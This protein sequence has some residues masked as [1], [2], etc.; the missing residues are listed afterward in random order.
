MCFKHASRRLPTDDH[1]VTRNPA[2]SNAQPSS[3]DAQLLTDLQG[4]F[5]RQQVKCYPTEQLLDYLA[6]IDNAPWAT[7]ANGKAITARHLARLLQPYG[8]VPKNIRVSATS[9]P[10]GYKAGDFDAAFTQLKGLPPTV[11]DHVAD[12]KVMENNNVA[13]N[14]I[15]R[16][17]VAATVADRKLVVAATVA[18]NLNNLV[19]V[20]DNDV[21]ATVADKV[22]DIVGVT[23]RKPVVADHVVDMA[24]RK[25]VV[26]A[27]V[28]VKPA[29]KWPPP[30][31]WA[32]NHQT[33]CYEPPK[34]SVEAPM[35]QELIRQ[36]LYVSPSLKYRPGYGLV[37][38][39]ET[40]IA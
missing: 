37:A 24:A 18:A 9:T 5:A 27:P 34:P 10:K 14:D 28:P 21:A 35:D 38:L 15:E 39:H 31:G 12:K 16:A 4:Y 20:A 26:A 40:E 1:P 23:D 33:G 30:K 2:M 6:G 8:I 29:R 36:T 13:A 17:D 19:N 3:L 7:F 11:A 22:A 32:W 25:R